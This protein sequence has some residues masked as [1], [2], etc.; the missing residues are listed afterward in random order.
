MISVS[1]QLAPMQILSVNGKPQFNCKV[2]RA[3]HCPWLYICV[4]VWI[5]FSNKIRPLFLSIHAPVWFQQSVE[6]RDADRNPP[7]RIPTLFILPLAKTYDQQFN[8]RNIIEIILFYWWKKIFFL[9]YRSIFFSLNYHSI[10]CLFL[11]ICHNFTEKNARNDTSIVG[12]EETDWL[13]TEGGKLDPA[14]L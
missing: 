7:Q 8:F 5:C 6:H 14:L 1:A 10:H 4:C 11:V 2:H 13:L 3:K 9:T 12:T